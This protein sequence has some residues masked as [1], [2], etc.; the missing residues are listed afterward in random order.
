MNSI[1][2]NIF[3]IIIS[4]IFVGIISYSVLYIMYGFIKYEGYNQQPIVKATIIFLLPVTITMIIGYFIEKNYK[5]NV[6]YSIPLSFI[7]ITLITFIKTYFENINQPKPLILDMRYLDAQLL[8]GCS[9]VAL[10]Y[11][12]LQKVL[13]TKVHVGCGII[14]ALAIV[15]YIVARFIKII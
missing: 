3:T 1:R 6:I 2:N 12:F 15:I 13:G 9:I 4:T 14:N 8:L 7:F 5:I 11:Y 10:I